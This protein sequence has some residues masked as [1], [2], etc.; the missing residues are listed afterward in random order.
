MPLT[1]AVWPQSAM[2][3]FGGADSMPVWE[4]IGIV[5]VPPRVAVWEPYTLVQTVFR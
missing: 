5:G 4:N 3:L 1:E 2:Q